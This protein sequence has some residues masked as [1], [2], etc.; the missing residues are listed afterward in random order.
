MTEVTENN[1]RVQALPPVDAT[2]DNPAPMASESVLSEDNPY[3]DLPSI[4]DVLEEC[5]VG[6]ADKAMDVRALFNTRY[7]SSLL[8]PQACRLRLL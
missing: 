3:G 2:N 5:S 4:F 8:Q 1:E 7:L 6:L